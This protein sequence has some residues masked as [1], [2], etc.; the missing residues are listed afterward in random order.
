MCLTSRCS[1]AFNI[2]QLSMLAAGLYLQ[3]WPVGKRPAGHCSCCC[4]WDA[5]DLRIRVHS[6]KSNVRSSHV[7]THHVQPVVT[8]WYCTVQSISDSGRVTP[9]RRHFVACPGFVCLPFLQN[10]ALSPCH[11]RRRRAS[12]GSINCVSFQEMLRDGGLPRGGGRGRKTGGLTFL[13]DFHIRYNVQVV[14]WAVCS[15]RPRFLSRIT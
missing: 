11:F 7:C 8:V 1:R 12:S 3:S 9:L 5:V 13:V 14:L 10:S 2:L 6:Y 15:A 4:R